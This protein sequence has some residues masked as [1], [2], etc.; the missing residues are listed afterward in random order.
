MAS[1]ILVVRGFADNNPRGARRL[2]RL[3]ASQ[4]CI[5]SI[6]WIGT[7]M[8]PCASPAWLRGGGPILD[9]G[10]MAMSG[11][12][13]PPP[14]LVICGL[15]RAMRTGH[16]NSAYLFHRRPLRRRMQPQ[17]LRHDAGFRQAPQHDEDLACEGDNHR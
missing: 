15:S 14:R 17:A 13:S 1:S 8:Q 7:M 11:F 3:A 5:R 6:Q 2:T 12:G 4:A 16:R 10:T 9:R